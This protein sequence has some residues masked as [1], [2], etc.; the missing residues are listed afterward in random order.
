ME[1]GTRVS[2]AAREYKNINDENETGTLTTLT[3]TIS[4]I[5]TNGK[6]ITVKTDDGRTFTR[7]VESMKEI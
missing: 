6:N 3:G 7:L 4:R 2:I 5:W 1:I